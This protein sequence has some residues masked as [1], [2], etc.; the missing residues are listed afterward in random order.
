MRSLIA[1]AYTEGADDITIESVI[2]KQQQQ[3]TVQRGRRKNPRNFS[4]MENK[5]NVKEA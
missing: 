2:W 3:R 4:A 1:C 5:G